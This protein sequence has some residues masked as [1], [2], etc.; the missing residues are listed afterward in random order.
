[1]CFSNRSSDVTI[2]THSDP[3]EESD[4]LIDVLEGL[5][6]PQKELPSKYFYDE[7]GSRLFDRICTLD[8]YY[9][10]RTEMRIMQK[11]IDEIVQLIG[12]D[13]LLVEYGSGSSLKT[14]ILLEHMERPA[15][16]VPIDIS[17]EHLLL[18]ARDLKK[19]FPDI[20]VF[21]V[22]ADYSSK[23]ELP[24]IRRNSV[25]PVVYFPGSTIGN[26]DPEQAIHFLKRI[27]KVCGEGGGLLIG[28]DL[29]KDP[30]VLEAAYDDAEGVTAAFNLNL[31][32]RINRELDGNFDVDEFEHHALYDP[33]KG[34][35]EMHLVSLIEQTVDLAGASYSFSAG[36]T[37]HT[38]NSYKY[39]LSQFADL[40]GRAGFDVRRVWTDSKCYFSVQYLV[41]K[42]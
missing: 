13:V 32:H 30:A 18:S 12:L 15:G 24:E 4:F 8:E 38:E 25:R 33:I 34:R 17:K 36:E 22:H 20:E 10:T 16:Y 40:A 19:E 6:Q 5:S 28:A 29:Q 3:G 7:E 9:P 35:I 26:F 39:T 41:S 31:L 11:N 37:I 23:I 14:R 21:P 2:F 1:M 27:A 42:G